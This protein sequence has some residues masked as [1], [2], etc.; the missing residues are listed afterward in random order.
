MQRKQSIYRFN[1]ITGYWQHV[2]NVSS[3]NAQDWLRAF[4]NDEPA[5]VFVLSYRKPTQAPELAR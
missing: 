2:R 5:C 3:D 1:H 4:Q